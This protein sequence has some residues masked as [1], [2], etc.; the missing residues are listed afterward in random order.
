MLK[1][2]QIQDRQND[3]DYN[4]R[5]EIEKYIDGYLSRGVFP[6]DIPRTRSGWARSN[7]LAVLELYREVGWSVVE[8]DGPYVARFDRI[9]VVAKPNDVP[10]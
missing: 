3:I 5:L 1:P 4:Q 10:R 9:Y 8:Q 2:S 7:T 6:C